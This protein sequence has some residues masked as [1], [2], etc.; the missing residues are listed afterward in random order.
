MIIDARGVVC[1]KPVLMVEE[2]LNKTSEETVEILVDN[3]ASLNNIK[4]FATKKGFYAQDTKIDNYWNVKIVKGYSCDE[5]SVDTNKS[6]KELL[7][8][9]ATDTMGKD[10]ALGR[11]LMKAYFETMLVYKELPDCIFFMN[12]AIRLT[13]VDDEMVVI[14]KKISEMGVEIYTCGTCLKHFNLEDGLKVGMRG[15][16]NHIIEGTKDF[17]KTLWIG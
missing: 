13:T 10:E 7:I 11:V 14:L 12:T 3:E 9:I 5:T 4:R 17:K 8:I 6:K 15:T 2:E 1:P 16:T